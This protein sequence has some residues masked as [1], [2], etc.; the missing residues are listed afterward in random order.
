MGFHRFFPTS[1]ESDTVIGMIDSGIWPE[2]DS[3]NGTGFGAPPAKWK[4]TCQGSTNFTCNNKII[5]ARYYKT[6][7]N[8]GPDDIKS[9][10]DEKGHGTHTA[11]TAVGNSVSMANLFGYASG[12]AR[13][14]VPSA[15]I[16][17]YKVCWS[18]G[19][20]DAD[21]LA[22]F[23]DAIADGVD[24]LS[25][26]VGFTTPR[27][28]FSDSIAIG[29]FHAIRNGILTSTAAGNEGPD[30][31]TITNF[32]PWFISVAAST[33]D[34]KFSTKGI[35][36]NTFDLQNLMHPLIYGGDA[37]NTTGGFTNASSR[38]C[39][40][41]SLD[42]NLVKGKIVLCD[43]DGSGEE[44]FKAGAAG[45][46]MRGDS[47]RD[48]PSSFPLPA[49][50]VDANDGSK[51]FLYMNSTRNAT[52]TIFKSAEVSDTLA[53]YIVSFSSRGPNPI[54]SDILKPDISA[55]GV[56]ILAAWSL[57]SPVS[58]IKGQVNPIKALNPGL[59][60]DA[61]TIDYV[62]FLCGQGYNTS[63]L[64]LVTG[65]NSTCSEMING[66]VW[67]LNYPSFALS[68]LPT[69][70]SNI[71]SRVFKRVVTN[72]GSTSSTYRASVTAPAGLKIQA[73]P[74]VLSFTSLGQKQNF[75]VTI[76]GAIN[77][78]I[79]SASL[80]WDDGE[81]KVRSPIVVYVRS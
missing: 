60:Y 67:D 9:P 27:E 7:G 49:S 45:A 54:T 42:R 78:K 80:V 17:V 2:S 25:V 29:S 61:E 33:I 51:I 44:P 63:R 71:S 79:V 19:C 81:H 68:V 77:E 72:V 26:S 10:R 24:I 48:A 6:D 57:V 69:E 70:S 3:F 47:G 52:A 37:A 41:D 21:I 46:L 30:P 12:T 15:R 20:D 13:G 16:A 64:R 43:I 22:A 56:N 35:S 36:I 1:V 58:E 50:C 74:N 4:G 76:E 31:S 23:D 32:A 34:R 55:P 75:T 40:E 18:D 8:F 14:W 62:K 28:Y 38:I 5:G 59:V 73:N 66:T 11:S 53:P 65:D 39:E